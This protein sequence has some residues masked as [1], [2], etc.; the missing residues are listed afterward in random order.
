MSAWRLLETDAR[1]GSWNMACD[2]ALLDSVEHGDAPAT[3]RLY[4]WSPAAVSLG[5]HQPDPEPAAAALLASR[6]VEW[7]RRPTGGRAVW[8]GPP[9]HELTYS[10]AA[11]LD[12]PVLAAGPAGVPGGLAAAYRRIHEILAAALASLG[13]EAALAPRRPVSP[14]RVATAI[15]P[16]SRVA[17]F[18]AS[19]P[20]EITAGG[21][22][23]VGSAQRR[24]RRALLQHGSIPL[25]GEQ[26]ILA[27][28]WP[29][30]LAPSSATTVSAAAGREI[31]AEEAARAIADAFAAVLGMPLAP[32]A[33][34]ARERRHVE[35][36]LTRSLAGGDIDVL[37]P[38][39][40]HYLEVIP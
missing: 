1:P 12:E 38:P 14:S 10:V 8:H 6:G 2:A 20:H 19:V 17:C 35:S 13:I 11:R 29:G 25:A 22:K 33:L 40:S 5:R 3:L 30:S 34:S 27:D 32:G 26:G 36:T 28:A 16:T 37:G 9:E 15:R 21:R 7:V 24:G 23:L 39:S 18:A 4:A 31:G